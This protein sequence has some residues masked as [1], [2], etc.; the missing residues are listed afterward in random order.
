MRRHAKRIGEQLDRY[1]G[2]LSWLDAGALDGFADEAV[3]I[4]GPNLEVAAMPGRPDGIRAALGRTVDE[5]RA[6]V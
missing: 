4:L 3:S 2:D 6:V 1:G 5:V